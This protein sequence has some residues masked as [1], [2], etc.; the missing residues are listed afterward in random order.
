MDSISQRTTQPTENFILTASIN[1]FLDID[2]AFH[3]GRMCFFYSFYVQ[4]N[5][6]KHLVSRIHIS[7][8]F[9]FGLGHLQLISSFAA[10][11]NIFSLQSPPPVVNFVDAV[12]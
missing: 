4:S 2:N 11:S 1:I 8:S 9:F 10:V 5:P 7:R 6:S 3:F 12:V